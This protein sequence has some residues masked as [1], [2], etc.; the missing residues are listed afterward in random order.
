MT[1]RKMVSTCN[2]TQRYL[3]ENETF[4]REF[5]KKNF[6]VPSLER[7]MRD[8]ELRRPRIATMQRA[9][10]FLYLCDMGCDTYSR[11]YRVFNLIRT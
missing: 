9:N 10:V 6:Y 11:R 8:T 7:D 1:K 2:K 5:E 4:S 3:F